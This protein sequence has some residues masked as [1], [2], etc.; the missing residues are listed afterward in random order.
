[1]N[2]YKIEGKQHTDYLGSVE[3]YLECNAETPVQA[4]EIFDEVFKGS[5][6]ARITKLTEE[7]FMFQ[8]LPKSEAKP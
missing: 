8:V 5:K 7:K 3:A 1:M 6:V 2:H 4:R